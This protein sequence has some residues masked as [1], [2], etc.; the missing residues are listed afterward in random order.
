VP[1]RELGALLVDAQ[2]ALGLTQTT[3]GEI[4]RCSRRTVWRYQSGQSRPLPTELHE[5]ARRTFPHDPELAR[6]LAIA[7]GETLASLGIE[8]IA[9]AQP[10]PVKPRLSALLVDAIVCAAAE[11]LDVSPKS[12]R[13][14]LYAAFSRAMETE[15]TLE[16]VTQRLAPAAG[17]PAHKRAQRNA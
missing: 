8:P 4:L 13:P 2:R 12:V 6:R 17:G 16:E 11:A 9:P 14:A 5:L 7:A 3:L 10:A 1:A 15:L